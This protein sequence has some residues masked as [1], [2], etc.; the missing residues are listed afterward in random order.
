MSLIEDGEAGLRA[1]ARRFDIRGRRAFVTGGSLGIGRAI[2]LGLAEAGADVAIQT[3]LDAD[4]ALG[5]P[6]A[7]DGTKEA[8]QRL[9]RCSAVVQS[10]FANPGAATQALSS[11]VSRLGGIDILVIAAST[12]T[13]GAFRDVSTDIMA[14]HVAINFAATVELLQGVLPP[15]QARGWGRILSIGSV[16]QTK[17]DA[18]LA[19]YAALKAAQHNLV[20]NLARQYA[21]HGVTIN[22]LS[23]GLVET[24]RNQWRRAVP[25]EWA[26]L[27][28][29]YSPMQRAAHPEEMVGP[30]LLLCSDAGSFITGSDLQATG[31]GHL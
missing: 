16:N 9:C 17:P 20:I 15:M 12:Q 6:D 14:R 31:G 19:V 21:A 11:A 1:V 26:Q 27:Q 8:L 4:K 30:A 22:T 23:P 13:N 10:D 25:E 7:A 29:R 5:Y 28:K 3:S 24:A 18:E 2:A